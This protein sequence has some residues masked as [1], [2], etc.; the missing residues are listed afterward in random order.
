MFIFATL[1]L[2]SVATVGD[3]TYM[4]GID[5]SVVGAEMSRSFLFS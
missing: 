1:L 4:A 3:D 2:L 5:R